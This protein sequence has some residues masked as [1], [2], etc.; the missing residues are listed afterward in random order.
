[1]PFVAPGLVE[2]RVC[3]FSTQGGAPE[4][5]MIQFEL[6][7]NLVWIRGIEGL[8]AADPP[9]LFDPTA[10][11]VDGAGAVRSFGTALRIFGSASVGGCVGKEIKRY[12]LNY[13]PGFV[14]NPNLPGFAPNTFW[15][16]NYNTPLQIDA[17]LN[18][19]FED[20]LTSTWREWHFPPGLCAPVS[21]WLQDAYWSTQ[22]PQSFPIVP[23]EPPCPPPASWNS[24]PLP[25][26]NCQSGRY[27]L[28]LTVEDTGGGIKHDLQQVWFDNKDIYGKIMQIFPVPPCS[29]I[30][31]SQFAI[32]GGDCSVAWPAQLHGIAY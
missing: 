29:T 15:Q 31:L 6:Q 4:C 22:V 13:H 27:T 26:I 12:T 32:A 19:I 3:V 7:R 21:N 18:R 9:G 23:S 20:V 30:N 24:I 17:G 28:R 14:V 10:P 11:L 1:F 16:V 8:E 2:I 25:L 5:C